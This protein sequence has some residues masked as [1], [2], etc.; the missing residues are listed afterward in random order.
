VIRKQSRCWLVG[1]LGLMLLGI[2]PQPALAQIE[3]QYQNRGDRHEGIKPKPVKGT[4]LELI[5]VLVDYQEPIS[6][7]PD[8]LKIKFFLETDQPV[9]ITVRELDYRHYY[10]MD[11]IKP[12][13]PWNVGQ[14]NTFTWST[15]TVLKA[16]DRNLDPYDLGILA[17]MDIKNPSR[18][19]HIAPVILYHSDEPTLVEGYLFTLKPNENARLFVSIVNEENSET[20]WKQVFRRK[21][22]GRPFTVKWDAT[23]SQEGPYRFVVKGFSLHTNRPLNQT[24]RFYHRPTVQ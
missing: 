20:I 14:F 10:W 17:R 8:Q 23:E 7:V 24:V 19:E 9:Y 11:Q 12:P 4:D 22:A 3:L 21:V 15:K 1:I 6:K 2:V 18:V 5:S 16:L 13:Q